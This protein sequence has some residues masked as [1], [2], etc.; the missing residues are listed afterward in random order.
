MA[1]N[2][3]HKRGGCENFTQCAVPRFAGKPTSYLE[4]GV[5][6]GLSLSWVAANILT[7]PDS[8]GIGVDPYLP[9]LKHDE[10][11][12]E[13]IHRDCLERIKPYPNV[14]QVREKS[15]DYLLNRR[16]TGVWQDEPFDLVYLDGS[17]YGPRVMTDGVLAWQYL[18]IGGM[19]IFD[20]YGLR[21]HRQ[22]YNNIARTIDQ[23]CECYEKHI[24]IIFTNY[25]LGFIKTSEMEQEIDD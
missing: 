4:I 25:Q 6:Q 3:F 23:F 13:Q 20:D 15:I 19:L 22:K 12:I 9:M 24:E 21:P 10:D 7:H 18:K 14:K 2:W 11:R 1:R 16:S 8:R 5:Y 17:H